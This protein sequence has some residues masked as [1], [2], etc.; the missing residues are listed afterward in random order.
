LGPCEQGRQGGTLLGRQRGD[1]SLQ[2]TRLLVLRRI[3][4]RRV[5]ILLRIA[6]IRRRINRWFDSPW[7]RLEFEQILTKRMPMVVAL[8]DGAVLP[9]TYSRRLSTATVV[10]EGPGMAAEAVC[11]QHGRRLIDFAGRPLC[12][13]RR[14]QFDSGLGLCVR[15]YRPSW[16]HPARGFSALSP[17]D[18]AE[19]EESCWR[20]SSGDE[21]HFHCGPI[22]DG[23]GESLVSLSNRDEPHSSTAL[24]DLLESEL[25]HQAK[26]VHGGGE[27]EII[28]YHKYPLPLV[29]T[30][31][32]GLSLRLGRSGGFCRYA[33]LV[34]LRQELRVELAAFFPG[35]L[36]RFQTLVPDVD[37]IL[38]SLS[39]ARQQFDR[40]RS[41]E[42][43]SWENPVPTIDVPEDVVT[44]RCAGCGGGV[45]P[46][47]L[48]AGSCC[49]NCGA[50]EAICGSV[51]CRDR[52]RR[53]F[54][55]LAEAANR[56]RPSSHRV[57]PAQIGD[58]P[59]VICDGCLGSFYL[60]GSTVL[61]LSGRPEWGLPTTF[62]STYLLLM[63]WLVACLCGVAFGGGAL[64][65]W[66]LA[67]I[68][69][70]AVI[71]P[72]RVGIAGEGLPVWLSLG[73]K[74]AVLL[75]LV[76]CMAWWFGNSESIGR[77]GL[78]IASVLLLFLSLGLGCGVAPRDRRSHI[79]GTTAW[80]AVSAVL[81]A[82]RFESL[83][84]PL[85]RPAAIVLT[86]LV[87]G[88]AVCGLTLMGGNGPLARFRA[89]PLWNLPRST[90]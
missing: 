4:R 51:H 77:A 29:G 26:R 68:A 72:W 73:L 27:G 19:P 23:P 25:W 57:P 50:G 86:V 71:E 46:T 41:P 69:I 18:P 39:L 1:K 55:E 88:A 43:T 83:S 70:L 56:L 13:F 31:A 35:S 67:V 78:A 32:V 17:A 42:F 12:S 30:T 53:T 37:A 49:R 52:A 47:D 22:G 89:Y 76:P 28:G 85:G 58:E 66:L 45:G 87:I 16:L 5:V 48:V 82:W 65:G 80:A 24:Y 90:T 14:G 21:L 61:Q 38:L 79:G 10:C 34:L 84:V 33:S 75:P 3:A 74:P 7:T 62:S 6:G 2:E 20:S 9:D 44:A 60:P 63:I 11:R 59:G 54:T 8:L 15:F 36:Q 64:L 81:Y 40:M